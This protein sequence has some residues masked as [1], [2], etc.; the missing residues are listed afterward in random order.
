MNSAVFAQTFKTGRLGL[1]WYALAALAAVSSGGL[2]LSAITTQGPALQGILQ[3]LP[4]AILEAF[5]IN[6]SS[7]TTPIGYISA[8]G[9]SLIWPLVM[10]AFSAGSA[11][12]VSALIERGTIHFELSL[13]VSRTRWLASRIV[14]A[15]LGAVL[16]CL[17]TLGG[18]YLFA[19]A[20]WW[21][22]VVLGFA[23]TVMGLGVAYATAAVA[24]DRA[25]VSAV[26]FGLFAVQFLLE[27]LSTVSPDAA[28]LRNLTVW[29]AYKPESTVLNGVD[30]GVVGAW[31]LIGALGF[32]VSLWRWN[33]RDLPA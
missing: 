26:V 25:T 29:S 4:P 32:A 3:S 10:V 22:F 7:F 27:T 13:P 16:L 20:D 17:V 31:L 9:L 12:G 18:L 28:W 33:A 2:G 5:K 6:L 23:F 21:R 24:R 30:W 11:S 1:L 15:L 14:A 8:R 19:N